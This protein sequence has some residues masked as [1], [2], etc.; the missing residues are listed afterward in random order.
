MAEEVQNSKVRVSIGNLAWFASN[1]LEEHHAFAILNPAKLKASK[2]QYGALGGGAMLTELGKCYLE[3]S[4]GASNFEFDNHTMFYDARFVIDED[5]V[6]PVFNLF[7]RIAGSPSELEHDPTLDIL[8][9]L[10]GTESGF[11]KR[12]LSKKIGSKVK[13]EFL[14]VVRQKP[15]AGADTSARAADIPTLRLFRIYVLQ[16][17]APTFILFEASSIVKF[18]SDKELTTTNGGSAGGVASDGTPIQ[19]N[20]F[21]PEE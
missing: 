19:N 8:Q 1:T 18:L 4:F 5:K 21:I 20:L 10:T 3:E 11:N 2:R 17:D 7:T 9:E 13:P 15:A 14:K 12:I 16:M 6:E